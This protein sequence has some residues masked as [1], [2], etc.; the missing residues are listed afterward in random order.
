MRLLSFAFVS[1]MVL[2]SVHGHLGHHHHEREAH[3]EHDV[4]DGRR[5]QGR[6]C[7]TPDLTEEEQLQD[8]LN[9]AAY[10]ENVGMQA[11]D[12]AMNGVINVDV[13][14]HTIY[15]PDGT[16]R[17][18]QDKVLKTMEVLNSYMVVSYC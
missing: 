4:T 12:E 7:G 18:P 6:S 13:Y 3:E 5:L 15:L 11:I 9:M 16:G 10:I 14:W 17:T 8:E 2:P 1:M